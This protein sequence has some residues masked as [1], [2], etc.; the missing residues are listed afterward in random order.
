MEPV[1]VFY[2][3]RQT[4]LQH[5]GLSP[6]PGKPAL[7]VAAWQELNL[8]MKIVEPQAATLT[9]L[10]RAHDCGYVQGVLKGRLP[11]GFGNREP[12]LNDTLPWTVGS[13]ISAADHVVIT[14][15]PAISPT[16]GF[17]HAGWDYGAAFCTF[18]GLMVAALTLHQRGLVKR[19]AIVDLDQHFGDGTR[20]IIRRLRLD[21]VQHYTY[22][23]RPA[24]V[25][26]AESWLAVLPAIVEETIQGCDLVLYQAGV[27]PHVD[28]M[29]RGGLTT[30]QLA[31]RDQIVFRGCR[32]ADVPLA[33]T[34]AGGYQ[35]PVE[36]VVDLHV[37]MFRRLVEVY[38]Q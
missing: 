14:T 38:W 6:S 26:T 29:F 17:H 37:S 24:T 8:P 12:D 15:E 2:T 25:D 36:R 18:N 33:V 20:D 11:N 9:D 28:D 4:A 31:R 32:E 35:R 23:A 27:D 5:R 21:W 16:S 3:P 34:L 10:C 7:V 30:D 1:H 19:V 13:M 22:G